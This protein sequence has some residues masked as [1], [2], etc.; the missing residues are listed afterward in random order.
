MNGI[1]P[2]QDRVIPFLIAPELIS[3]DERSNGAWSACCRTSASSPKA[4]ADA[5]KRRLLDTLQLEIVTTLNSLNTLHESAKFELCQLCAQ[6]PG[7]L[8]DVAA[9]QIGVMAAEIAQLQAQAGQLE[10]DIAELTGDPE[11]SIE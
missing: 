11:P 2:R 5:L 4:R 7:L 1:D 9:S 3:I 6:T 10:V 8:E